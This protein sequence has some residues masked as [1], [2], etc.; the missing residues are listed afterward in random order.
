MKLGGCGG[1]YKIFLDFE[2]CN[3]IAIN[4]MLAGGKFNNITIIN[5]N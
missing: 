3:N 4:N 1:T 5:S 2:G